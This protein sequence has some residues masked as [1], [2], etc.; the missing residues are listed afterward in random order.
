MPLVTEPVPDLCYVMI[1]G[2]GAPMVGKETAGRTGKYP[3]GRARTRE[4]KIGCLFTQAHATPDGEPARDEGS[5]SYIATFDDALGFA[6][7][8]KAEHSRR[9]FDQIRQPVVIGDGA[10]WIWTIAER[11]FPEA[12]HIVD[13]WHAREHVHD[14]VKIFD[15]LLP[16][17]TVFTHQ[18]IDHLDR[19]DID[20]M[21]NQVDTL[22]LDSYRGDI[23]ERANTALGYFT[24]NAHRMQY[25][26]YRAN[27][28][29]IGSG[30]VEA[31]CKVIVTQRAKQAGMRWTI[32]GLDP[33]LTL[34]TLTRSGRDR[35][36]WG[37]D[38]SQTNPASAA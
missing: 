34:R 15:H 33:I 9:G 31:A 29:F 23:S 21:I 13:Y 10:K 2:T 37:N 3:D 1:D 5:A 11:L 20:A 30:P 38:A 36:I 19:G 8:L 28:W 18:L 12:T 22:D 6:Q 4:V 24:V 7:Q 16:D 27:G 35:L 32:T 14:L 17:P 25:H 26:H